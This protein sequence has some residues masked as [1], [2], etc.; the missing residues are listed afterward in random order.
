MEPRQNQLP[1]IK[2][3]FS[4]VDETFRSNGQ[5]QN[6]EKSD[7]LGELNFTLA[8]P[9]KPRSV[10]WTGRDCPQCPVI[11][12][13]EPG[14]FM[15]GSPET[16]TE[17]DDERPR[18]RITFKAPFAIGKTEVTFAEFDACHKAGYCDRK[19]S[20]EGWGRGNLPVINVTRDEAI[21]YTRWLRVMTGNTYRLPS[22]AEW[23]YAARAGTIT[24]YP[25]GPEPRRDRA[26][27][28][29]EVAKDLPP[30]GKNAKAEGADIWL[31]TAPVGSF[32]KNRW[33]LFDMHGNV[34]EWIADCYPAPYSTIDPNGR[35]FLPDTCEKNLYGVRGGGWDSPP[36]HIR[37][38]FRDGSS[39]SRSFIGFRVARDN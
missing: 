21:A 37:S 4:R 5:R 23:E 11:T 8:A 36:E 19:P 18:T 10:G 28:G 29:A 20:D 35:A 25:W 12:I 39:I 2:D 14:S 34:A 38:A 26:N 30:P 15:I 27:Y 16:E 17:F 31:H 9:Q 3:V 6:P 24:A 32:P 7:K 22:E 13:L 1:F 33:G